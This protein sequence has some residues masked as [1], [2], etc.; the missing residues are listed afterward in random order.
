MVHCRTAF[1]LDILQSYGL[2]LEFFTPPEP[3]DGGVS[4]DAVR[5][6][7]GA[8]APAMSLKEFPP[9]VRNLSLWIRL[10]ESPEMRRFSWAIERIEISILMQFVT[11]NSKKY[12]SAFRAL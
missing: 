3:F 4:I 5:V 11:K 9:T 10:Q 6:I 12:L 1:Q 7:I 2:V 8:L